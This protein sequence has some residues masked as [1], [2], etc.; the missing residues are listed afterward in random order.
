MTDK[1]IENVNIEAEQPILTPN[2]LKDLYPLNENIIKTIEEG[3]NTIKNILSGKDKR[4]LVV[5]GP[6][7]IHDIKAAKEYAQKLKV[8]AEEVKESLYL[9]MRVYFEKPRTT[10]GWQG[11]INDPK[12]DNSFEIEE[13]LK[14][15]RA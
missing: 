13:G 14:Q 11:L 8:L 3:Q 15:A 10:V 5:V 9:V 2:Q 4:I 12:L 6:C 1:R 7:S